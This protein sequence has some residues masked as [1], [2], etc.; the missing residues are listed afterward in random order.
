MSA[1][2][3][4]P[5]FRYLVKFH[6]VENFYK[7]SLRI[8]TKDGDE[9]HKLIAPLI[10]RDLPSM[11]S[12]VKQ[13]LSFRALNGLDIR[14]IFIDEAGKD[15]A[16]I[17]EKSMLSNK[18]F[19]HGMVANVLRDSNLKTIEALQKKYL[20]SDYLTHL[21][22]NII[23]TKTQNALCAGLRGGKAYLIKQT[24]VNNSSV[25][26]VCLFDQTGL[27]AE[28]FFKQDFSVQRPSS[29]YFHPLKRIVGVINESPTVNNDDRTTH[30]V[31]PLQLGITPSKYLNLGEKIATNFN[32]LLIQLGV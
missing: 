26:K 14:Q 2:L 5:L 11:Q 3:S 15:G 13:Q 23:G 28:F 10:I 8:S 18:V 16:Y 29:H 6:V 31:T 32:D 19:M 1:I 7:R 12:H 30:I 9:N 20:P 24:A 17:L 4:D 21:P 27:R 22:D 25:G